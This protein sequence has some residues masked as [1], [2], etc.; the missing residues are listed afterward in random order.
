VAEL[1]PLPTDL[2]AS[3]RAAIARNTA[4][5]AHADGRPQ[6]SNVYA[7]LFHAPDLAERI[8]EL[9]EQIRFSGAL[10]DDVR[11]LAILRYAAR[12]RFGYEWSHHQRPAH[13]AGLD[14]ATVDAVTAGDAPTGLRPEQQAALDAVDAVVGGRPIPAGTQA[15]LVEAVGVEGVVELVA[16]CG[17]YA[18][19]GYT[20]TA[21]AL[22]VEDGLPIAPFD[23]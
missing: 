23:R 6:L 14:R 3:T 18:L 9:G 4:S 1:P 10:P 2:P 8:S 20:A 13:L 19:M 11:E 16:V 7:A 17:L 21:F 22:P 15:T 12:M 5:R